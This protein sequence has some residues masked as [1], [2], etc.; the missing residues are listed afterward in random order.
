M[1]YQIL[2]GNYPTLNSHG[3][4][5]NN[6]N[7]QENVR[8]TNES[9]FNHKISFTMISTGS[10]ILR[11]LRNH[12]RLIP[13]KIRRRALTILRLRKVYNAPM[14]PPMTPS[15]TAGMKAKMLIGIPF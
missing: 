14:N 7:Q 5:F 8:N 12:F 1:S 10:P 9:K 11:T 6:L 13:A 4:L 3:Y 2:Y 15:I